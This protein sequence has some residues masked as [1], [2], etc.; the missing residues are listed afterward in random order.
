[1]PR[2]IALPELDASACMPLARACVTLQNVIC[3]RFCAAGLGTFCIC[4]ADW[5]LGPLIPSSHSHGG[6]GCPLVFAFP[7]LVLGAS[8][9][10]HL[11][12][13]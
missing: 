3:A 13:V 9:D 11:D 6:S 7:Q 5:V 12:V 8:L 10:M 4:W 2:A 1:M